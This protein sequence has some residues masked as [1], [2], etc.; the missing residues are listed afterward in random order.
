LVVL[1]LF[2][3]MELLMSHMEE[4]QKETTNMNEYKTNINQIQT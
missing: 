4:V 1:Y 3:K 2:I